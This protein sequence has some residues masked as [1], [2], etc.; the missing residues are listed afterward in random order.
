M[1][2]REQINGLFGKNGR[3]RRNDTLSLNEFQSEIFGNDLPSAVPISVISK[4]MSGKDADH[5]LSERNIKTLER[6]LK[7]W[8]IAVK[9]LERNSVIFITAQSENE[10]PTLVSFALNQQ[11]DG[12]LVNK[13][14]SIHLQE[15]LGTY[16]EML[17]KTATVF[18]K[19][20]S[21]G[22]SGTALTGRLNEIFGAVINRLTQNTNTVI[23][24]NNTTDNNRS[25]ANTE[26]YSLEMVDAI[27]PST[28]KWER[29]ATTE[30][31][32]Q[33]YPDLWN[34]AADEAKNGIRHR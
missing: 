8:N 1:P 7:R 18:V 5:S 16:L 33:L 34:V 32:M 29:G 31:V 30:E 17:P 23:V 12:D 20:N 28:N 15:D 27:L 25:Q 3:I 2:W 4:A 22:S 24:K 10:Y 9:N 26:K 14:T 21:I 13:A 6:D 11:F 19:E